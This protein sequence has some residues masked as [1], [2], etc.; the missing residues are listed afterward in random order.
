MIRRKFQNVD[1]ILIAGLMATVAA[2]ALFLAVGTSS[3]GAAS[4][5]VGMPTEQ[6]TVAGDKA[7]LTRKGKAIAPESAPE[8][9]KAAIAAANKIRN[10]PY[11]YGG[12]HS[13]FNDKG[14]DCSGAVSY[15]LRGGRFLKSPMPSTGYMGGWGEKGKGKWITTYA[16][17]GHMYTVIA[18]LRWDTSGTN[19]SGPS[20]QKTLRSPAGG[21][22]VV[23]HPKGH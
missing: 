11:I 13:S 5:G 10:K 12:G 15:A 2:I 16:N 8:R 23:R 17:S 20:W 9:V 1:P 14:Y 19:G 7:R 3:A 21:D 22:Y 18:G 6:P 4:G